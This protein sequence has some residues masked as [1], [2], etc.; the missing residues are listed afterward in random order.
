MTHSSSWALRSFSALIPLLAVG[1]YGADVERGG[2]K[3]APLPTSESPSGSAG[4][5][6]EGDEPVAPEG[7]GGMPAEV[8][9]SEG[10]PIDALPDLY[11]EAS[12]EANARCWEAHYEVYGGWDC[13]GFQRAYLEDRL[14]RWKQAIEEGKAVYD[15]SQ[16]EA[17]L[18]EMRS[19]SCGDFLTRNSNACLK[20]LNG[21]VPLGEECNDDVECSGDTFCEFGPQ[22]PG[23]CVGR[24][25]RG[26]HCGDDDSQCADGLVC[27]DDTYRCVPPGQVGDS[28]EAGKPPCMPGLFCA[29]ADDEAA[30]PGEC[31]TYEDVF[32][33]KLGEVCDPS[34]D[35]LCVAGLRCAQFVDAEGTLRARCEPPATSGSACKAGA[36]VG[37]PL[38]EYCWREDGSSLVGQCTPHPGAGEPCATF[39]SESEP[40]ICA[41]DLVCVDG[42]CQAQARLGEACAAHAAC[43]SGNCYHSV[44]ISDRGCDWDGER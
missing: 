11:A 26:N 6:A 25:A 36:G 17:C 4:A 29:E 1:C 15:A 22:C 37:C 35:E 20:V 9:A 3:A 23:K 34:S 43:L 18:T 14:S 30:L 40:V 13:V 38:D 44:C 2:G 10:V 39:T 12:C 5:G 33:R 19:Q 27:S 21:A 41:R 8:P 31:K 42:V 32:S 16:V 24:Q 7:N 28:C